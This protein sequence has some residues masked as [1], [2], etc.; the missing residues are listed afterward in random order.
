MIGRKNVKIS[1]RPQ[2]KI[3]FIIIVLWLLGWFTGLAIPPGCSYILL[4]NFFISTTC[5]GFILIDKLVFI[6]DLWIFIKKVV[7][8]RFIMQL[9]FSVQCTIRVIARLKQL[10]VKTKSDFWP[11]QEFTSKEVIPLLLVAPIVDIVVII[12]DGM[13][14]ISYFW[15]QTFY[16]WRVH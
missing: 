2:L 11:D 10:P 9:F 16:I 6:F 5:I 14:L 12:V 3:D 13:A 7:I 8:V 1:S 4:H 15:H